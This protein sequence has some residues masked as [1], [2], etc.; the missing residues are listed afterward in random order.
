MQTFCMF[1]MLNYSFIG[2]ECYPIY[3][4]RAFLCHSINY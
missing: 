4:I 2:N 3:L 1:A